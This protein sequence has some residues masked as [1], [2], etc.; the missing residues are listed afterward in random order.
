[1]WRK[2]IKYPSLKVKLFRDKDGT[3]KIKK[4]KE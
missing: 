2:S 1:M 3:I 4:I